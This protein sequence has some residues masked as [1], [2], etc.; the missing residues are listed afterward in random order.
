MLGDNSENGQS[1][2]NEEEE[3]EED[4]CELLRKKSMITVVQPVA[5]KPMA[6]KPAATN[7]MTNTKP[8]LKKTAPTRS[9]TEQPLA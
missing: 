9:S 8:A 1:E 2:A 5:K 7:S 3:E 6:T 4:E